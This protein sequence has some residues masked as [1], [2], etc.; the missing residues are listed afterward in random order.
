MV[1][2]LVFV[3]CNHKVIIEKIQEED[4]NVKIDKKVKEKIKTKEEVLEEKINERIEK[5]TLREMISQTL[6]LGFNG[7]TMNEELSYLIRDIK[8]G[9]LILF[10]RNIDDIEKLAQ[11]NKSIYD[12]N[13]DNGNIPIFIS[14]DEEGG[15]VSR[16]SKIYGKLPS[17]LELGNKNDES[18]SVLYGKILGL[19]LKYLG[20]NLNFA[21][22]VDI[23]HNLDNPVM[24]TRSISNNPDIVSKNAFKL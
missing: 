24:G 5:M 3:S 14:V 19:R 11:L 1:L 6:I 23:N 20:F 16:L 21:P 18:I 15:D 17:M 4:I 2:A 12:L 8:P 10:D 22:V 7:S 9:G 13:A